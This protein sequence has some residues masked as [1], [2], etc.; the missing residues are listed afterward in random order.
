MGPKY[1]KSINWWDPA[2]SAVVPTWNSDWVSPSQAF[3]RSWRHGFAT[4]LG[5][6][7]IVGNFYISFVDERMDFALTEAGK[8]VTNNREIAEVFTSFFACVFTL[9]KTK[10]QNQSGLSEKVS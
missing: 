5:G 9:K 7:A 4:M 10:K 6:L 2:F 3:G 8:K 1:K